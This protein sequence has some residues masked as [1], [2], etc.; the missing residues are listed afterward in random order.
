[1]ATTLC[2]T[3]RLR[4]AL[5][6]AGVW[7][8]LMIGC[9]K[10]PEIERGQYVVPDDTLLVDCEPGQ[11]GGMFVLSTMSAP[12]SFNFLGASS[13]STHSVLN[14]LMGT[15]LEYDPVEQIYT[16][17]L[18]KSWTVDETN[19]RYVFKLREG[20]Q[21]SDGAPFTVDDVIFTFNVIAAQKLDEQAGKML[22]LYPTKYYSKLQY[23]DSKLA[24][25][26]IDDYTLVIE[27]PHIMPALFY[28]LHD[29]LI[30]P[31]H[32]LG[33]AHLSEILL[34]QW[35]LQTAI[36]EPEQIVGLGPFVV[37]SY[38][39]SERLVLTPNPHYWKADSAGTRLPYMDRMIYKYVGESSTSTVHLATGQISGGGVGLSS[40]GRVRKAAE[41]HDMTIHDLG[42]ST[43]VTMI[44]L[45]QNP[46]RN[47]EGAPYVDPVKLKW[48]RN[49]HFRQALYYGFNR[50]E[51]IDATYFGGGIVVNSSINPAMGQWHNPNVKAYTYDPAKA[52]EL[53]EF[54]GFYQDD[55]GQLFDAEG[56]RVAFTL[57]MPNG[58]GWEDLVL[59]FKQNM[60]D[61]GMD[62][63][64]EPMEF[65][66]LSAKMDYT[67]DFDGI[68]LAWGYSSAA[69]DPSEDESF[70]LSSGKD[71]NW[72]PKQIE[73][74]RDWEAR[75][76]ELYRI[77]ARTLDMK[78]RIDAMHEI[79]A[80][81][82]E[83]A[84]MILMSS[85]SEF[86]VIQNSWH[87]IKIPKSGPFIWNIEE[88]W[89]DDPSAP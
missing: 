17:A 52:L 59:S 70:Y 36:E 75:I 58:G 28:T 65:S 78:V 11:Y 82:A 47:E 15:L 8:L 5:L 67:Y 68:V 44:W 9:G 43:S 62:V 22:P 45:N 84:P 61:L 50:Q 73:P 63:S 6:F 33:A 19:T 32:K 31:K 29:I 14:K 87:N 51:V 2:N 53:L 1:M 39:P 46:G 89:T 69:Y 81:I 7:A 35:S 83:E 55:R 12:L 20:I 64:L 40:I 27:T 21:W 25:S 80:I 76:D 88:L 66:S 3:P 60:A 57:L 74:D 85:G 37:E 54:E 56:N 4:F 13:I 34:K 42:P 79:Q 38:K 72:H 30:L 49:K 77:Q 23:G 41:K 26:K 86:A 24:Y 16:P 18:A 71:H 10:A 48:F